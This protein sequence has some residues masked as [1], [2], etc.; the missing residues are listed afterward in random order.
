M[1]EIPKHSTNLL[2]TTSFSSWDLSRKRPRVPWAVCNLLCRVATLQKE[3]GA[4][5]R[6]QWQLCPCRAGCT[7]PER[8]FSG[9]FQV[10][11]EHLIQII[12]SQ[13]KRDTNVRK[14]LEMDVGKCNQSFKGER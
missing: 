14:R 4:V 7:A 8:T 13:S 5:G 12:T 10:G 1:T 2:E 9:G 3:E 6:Q 11:L